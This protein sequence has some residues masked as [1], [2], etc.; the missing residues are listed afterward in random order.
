VAPARL[1]RVAEERRAAILVVGDRRM[2]PRRALPGPLIRGRGGAAVPAA[3]LP[4]AGDAALGLFARA[5]ARVRRRAGRLRACAVLGQWMPQYL[6]LADRIAD[7]L[8][9]GGCHAFRWTSDRLA[10]A[11]LPRALGVGLGLGIYVGHGRPVGWVGY[12]GTRLADLASRRDLTRAEPLGALVSLACHTASRHRVG[13]SFAE[14]LPLAGVAAAALGAVGPTLHADNARWAV[15]LARAL[16]GGP[17]A[18]G[19]ATIGELIVT[20]APIADEAVA[21]YRI[22]GDPLAPLG[23]RSAGVAAGRA[24][25]EPS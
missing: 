17:G 16:G 13:L 18:A 12:Y 2:S 24:F 19:A 6:R 25:G 10:R 11:E 21:A 8:D 22:I 14:A 4:D 20:S 5:A 1:R 7:M 15:G 3:W 23:S 9:T